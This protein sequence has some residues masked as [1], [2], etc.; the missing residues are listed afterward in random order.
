MPLATVDRGGALTLPTYLQCS[1]RADIVPV[2][3]FSVDKCIT[4]MLLS[5]I[6]QSACQ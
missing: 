2:T 1:S 5:M 3:Y 4:G 6:Y